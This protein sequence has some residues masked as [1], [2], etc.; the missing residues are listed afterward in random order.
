MFSIIVAHDQD[1]GIAKQ[2]QLPWGRNSEDMKHFVSMT[3]SRIPGRVNAVIM[4]RKTYRTLARPLRGRINIV[5]S[6]SGIT[7]LGNDI[8]VSGNLDDAL[9]R[10]SR[11]ENLDRVFVIGGAEVYACA[12]TDLRCTHVHTTEFPSS[13]DSDQFFPVLPQRFTLSHTRVS[14]SGLTFNDYSS[15]LGTV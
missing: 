7:G 12:I 3:T 4:G 11:I 13:Y 5:L 8:I 14:D 2:G 10:A 1:R 6:R 15:M 9:L